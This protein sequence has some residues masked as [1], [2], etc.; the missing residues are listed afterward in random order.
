MFVDVGSLSSLVNDRLSSSRFSSSI[1]LVGHSGTSTQP[2][3]QFRNLTYGR[4]FESPN[5]ASSAKFHREWPLAATELGAIVIQEPKSAIFSFL[6]FVTTYLFWQQL[7]W[8]SNIQNKQIWRGYNVIGM[9]AWFLSTIFHCVDCWVTK[10]MY[11][12]YVIS[13]TSVWHQVDV[14]YTLPWTT[15]K[16]F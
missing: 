15:K 13:P 14:L 10:W 11:Y 9:I 2:C 5:L 6:T 4:S 8:R 16:H 12:F 1:R 7:D 3:F